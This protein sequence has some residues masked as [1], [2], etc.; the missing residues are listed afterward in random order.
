MKHQVTYILT[1]RVRKSVRSVS[2]SR[3]ACMLSAFFF[4]ELESY[5][6]HL[7]AERDTAA[8]TG[9]YSTSGIHIE[10]ANL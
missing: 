6:L 10:A 4:K 2:L 8:A 3:V 7:I 5:V 9:L 1:E